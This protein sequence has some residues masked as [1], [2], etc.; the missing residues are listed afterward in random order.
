VAAS[1]GF[2]PSDNAVDELFPKLWRLIPHE[3]VKQ[4]M[5]AMRA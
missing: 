3:R 2:I 1:D 5:Q 4:Q